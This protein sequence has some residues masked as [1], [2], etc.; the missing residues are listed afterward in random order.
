MRE[1][2]V[3]SGA[4]GAKGKTEGPAQAGLPVLSAFSSGQQQAGHF[5]QAVCHRA[6]GSLQLRAGV[7]AACHQDAPHAHGAGHGGV[8]VGVAHH[9][10]AGRVQPGGAQPVQPQLHLAHAVNIRKA[11]QLIKIAFQAALRHLLDQV[12]TA[13]GGEDHLP[14]AGIA[15]RAERLLRLRGGP[16]GRD[17]RVVVIHEL[18][19]QQR[20]GV[21]RK[22]EA[23]AAVVVLDGETEDLPVGIQIVPLRIAAM[24]QQPVQAAEGIGGVVQQGTV[25]VPEDQVYRCF[26]SGVFKERVQAGVRFD[27]PHQ[28]HAQDAAADDFADA[29]GQRIKEDEPRCGGHIREKDGDLRAD[30]GGVPEDGRQGRRNG[31]PLDAQVAQ[32]VSTQAGQEGGQRA[33]HHVDDGGTDQVRQQAAQRH[34]HDVLRAEHGQQAQRLRDADLHR[35]VGEGRQR[36]AQRHIQRRDGCAAHDLAGGKIHVHTNTPADRF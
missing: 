29:H 1:F 3:N 24:L 15:Q 19:R 16:T 9:H 23:R 33:E 28:G 11:E 20:V 6:A 30:D 25:P 18:L 22:V 36:Q 31:Q 7:V 26:H 2:S 10:T 17:P 34:G 27:Q 35:A 12:I 14:F 5:A 21:P 8:V 4:R 32:L 13:A